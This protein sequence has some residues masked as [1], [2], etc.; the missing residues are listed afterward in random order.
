MMPPASRARLYELRRD[1]M[2]AERGAELLERKREA[3]LRETARCAAR[4]SALRLHVEAAYSKARKLLRIA[5]AD[6]GSEA[7]AAAGLAQ[8]MT[9]TISS[10]ASTIMGVRIRTLL[11]ESRASLTT[12]TASIRCRCFVTPTST[13]W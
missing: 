7:V 2:T 4:V 3:L 12:K 10:R 5:E 13:C 11:A 6:L 1:R 9:C 8:A